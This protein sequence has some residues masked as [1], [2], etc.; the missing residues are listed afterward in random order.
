M[1]MS[2]LL[3]STRRCIR[4][5]RDQDAGASAV[6]LALVL[7]ILIVMLMGIIEF[8]RAWNRN[9]VITD[10][11]REGTRRAVVRDGEDKSITV[12]NVVQDRLTVSG[13]TWDGALNGYGASC[14]DWTL[15][16]PSTRDLIVS[17]CGWGGET[18]SEARV[19]IFAPY[20]FNFLRPIL[21]LLGGS[22]TMDVA[23]LSTNFVMRNE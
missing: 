4:N 7:P 20:P 22:T 2:R 14:T 12:T 3:S 23:V 18:G 19:I 1:T 15:P 21:P 10:A 11:A 13:L 6:E 8:G 16:A 9:Q 5:L 17:G